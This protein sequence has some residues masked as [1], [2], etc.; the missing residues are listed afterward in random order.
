[1]TSDDWHNACA[2]SWWNVIISVLLAQLRA[3]PSIAAALGLGGP[4]PLE[5]T[6]ATTSCACEVEPSPWRRGSRRPHTPQIGEAHHRLTGPSCRLEK[7]DTHRSSCMVPDRDWRDSG[8][9]G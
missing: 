3:M 9:P 5:P 8:R 1:M 4:P 7:T 6:A 2:K